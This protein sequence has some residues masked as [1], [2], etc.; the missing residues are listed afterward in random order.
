MI[1]PSTSAFGLVDFIPFHI[2]FF[3][4]VASLKHFFGKPGDP[5]DTGIRI[6]LSLMRQVSVK[7]TRQ[8]ATRSILLG[9]AEIRPL[10]P[11]PSFNPFNDWATVDYEGELKVDPGMKEI[12][13][14]GFVS[15]GVSVQVRIFADAIYVFESTLNKKLG[16]Y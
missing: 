11:P 4:T 8:E 3:G 6:R 7:T 13:T 9:K 16:F 10:P 14:G 1:I 15:S 2:E 12:R 5:Q